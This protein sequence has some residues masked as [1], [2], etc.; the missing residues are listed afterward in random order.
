MTSSLNS[1]LLNKR[2]FFQKKI[3]YF[4]A[5]K[6]LLESLKVDPLFKSCDFSFKTAEEPVHVEH[7]PARDSQV[8]SARSH[9]LIL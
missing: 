4:E 5:R 1:A 2:M 3:Y 9:A 7:V 8:C 6:D